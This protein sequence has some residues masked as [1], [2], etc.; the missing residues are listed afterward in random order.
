MMHQNCLTEEL[1]VKEVK[2]LKG[3]IASLNLQIQGIRRLILTLD[4]SYTSMYKILYENIE[5]GN[6]TTESLK[7]NVVRS[8]LD[9][10]YKWS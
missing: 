3:S 6:L 10:E 2:E 8:I 9:Q 4:E 5:N 1:L 7:R